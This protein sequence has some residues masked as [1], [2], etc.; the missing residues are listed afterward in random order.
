MNG[1]P[2]ATRGYA[3][4]GICIHICHSII[5]SHLKYQR[6]QANINNVISIQDILSHIHWPIF[7]DGKEESVEIGGCYFHKKS[8]CVET[9]DPKGIWNKLYMSIMRNI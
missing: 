4:L 7:E 3:S 6:N 5:H 1:S 9:S 2:C 8:C